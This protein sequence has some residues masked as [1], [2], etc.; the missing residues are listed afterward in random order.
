MSE[1]RLNQ[2][3]SFLEQSPNDPF[4]KYAIATEHL[5]LG[6]DMLALVHF[7]QLTEEHPDYVGTYYHLGKLYEKLDQESNAKSVYEKGVVIAERAGNY[8]AKSELLGALNSME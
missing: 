4:I 3:L 6:K 5:K 8:H 1:K 2:L 7:N